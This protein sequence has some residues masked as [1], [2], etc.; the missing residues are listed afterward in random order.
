MTSR[1]TKSYESLIR[2]TAQRLAHQGVAMYVVDARGLAVTEQGRAESS[3]QVQPRRDRRTFAQEQQASQISDDPSRAGYQLADVTGGRVFR[4]NNDSTEGIQAVAADLRGAYSLG[5]YASGDPDDKWRR[6]SVKVNRKGVKVLQAKGY[7]AESASSSPTEWSEQQWSAAISSPLGST[8]IHMD[9]AATRQGQ[10]VSVVLS[11]LQDD[12]IFRDIEGLRG[13]ELEVALVGK[14]AAGQFFVT[15]EVLQARLP[16]GQQVPRGP[17]RY[18]QDWQAPPE[19]VTLRLIA[20]DK[21][22]GLS[23]VLDL[24][25]A[26]IPQQ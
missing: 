20:R 26:G 22:T 3:A 2:N 9:A 14:T 12:V 24:P 21:F 7:L 16:E 13:A 10:T 25:L 4:N 5:F 19:A 15:R 23:G 6:I 8:G 1:K 17:I 11:V 18:E